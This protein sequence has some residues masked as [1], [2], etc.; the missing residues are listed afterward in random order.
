MAGEVALV[1]NFCR[2]I[3]SFYVSFYL[4]HY[5]EKVGYG[6][7]F[8]IYAIL[9]VVLFIPILVLMA[10]GGEIRKR[11]GKPRSDF[12]QHTAP[13]QVREWEAKA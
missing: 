12:V 4:P 3:F 11:L 13:V 2:Q 7:A 1:L 10:K 9:A 8:G 6:W 5:T